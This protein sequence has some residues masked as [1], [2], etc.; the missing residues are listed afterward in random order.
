MGCHLL[1]HTHMM[2]IIGH[3]IIRI[4]MRG[5]KMPSMCSI[6]LMIIFRENEKDG[7]I[8]AYRLF[9]FCASSLTLL[10]VYSFYKYVSESS[11]N[12]LFNLFF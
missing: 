4:P 9:A 10:Y 7:A 11:E 12:M 2:H 1:M 8:G 6:R 5:G 3:G